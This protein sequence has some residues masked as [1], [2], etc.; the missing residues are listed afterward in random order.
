MEVS[1]A[2][3]EATPENFQDFDTNFGFLAQYER[4]ARKRTKSM[5]AADPSWNPDSSSDD[6][7]V[8]LRS[9][10]FL[11]LYNVAYPRIHAFILSLSPNRSDVNDAIQ[12]TSLVLLRR[13]DDFVRPQ[14]GSEVDAFVRWG[15]GIALNQV[16][17]LKREGTHAVPF[18]DAL[19]DRIATAREQY[20]DTLELRR[21]HLPRC[22]EKLSEA[23]RELASHC[24]GQ[25]ASI[26]T[27]AEQI[28]RPV[29]TLYKAVNR[30]RTRL[31]ECVDLAMRREEQL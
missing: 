11:A 24:F 25:A 9:E 30:I 12:E 22:L 10:R 17:R 13:F 2:F 5:N 14:E 27:V 28:G 23:D 15:C 20:S 26:K 3:G 19:I 29:N 7:V 31:K 18:S 1:G 21:R 16:R 6:G 8:S 4:K